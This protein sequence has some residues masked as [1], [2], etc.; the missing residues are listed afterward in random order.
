LFFFF[1]LDLPDL[2][3]H[4]GLHHV[5]VER[6]SEYQKSVGIRFSVFPRSGR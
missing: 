5:F 3:R 6:V 4:H 1:L 2:I